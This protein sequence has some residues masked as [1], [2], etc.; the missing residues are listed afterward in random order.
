MASFFF[1]LLRTLLYWY[2]GL[3]LPL[4]WRFVI[5]PSGAQ[6][7]SELVSGTTS[8]PLNPKLQDAGVSEAVHFLFPRPSSIF[9]DETFKESFVKTKPCILHKMCKCA[10]LFFP[11][12]CS[13]WVLAL[14]ERSTWS[15][16]PTCSSQDMKI[17]NDSRGSLT[18]CVSNFENGSAC[19]KWLFLGIVDVLIFLCVK[20]THHFLNHAL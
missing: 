20:N 6:S 7:P 12:C 2:Q 3:S 9:H 16:N 4:S 15:R 11:E 8:L 1:S 17:P 10:V 18:H 19:L 13:P 14:P 5:E